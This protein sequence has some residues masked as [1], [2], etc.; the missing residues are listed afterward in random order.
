MCARSTHSQRGGEGRHTSVHVPL[1]CCILCSQSK[2][3]SP[4]AQVV[5]TWCASLALSLLPL[6][7]PSSP[8]AQQ[9]QSWDSRGL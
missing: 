5:K 7:S 6:G 9:S 1:L 4:L 8:E 3:D 2:A